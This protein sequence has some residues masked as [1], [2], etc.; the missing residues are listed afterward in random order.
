VLCRDHALDVAR[1]NV[2]GI[3]GKPGRDL[4][5]PFG[6][7]GDPIEPLLPVQRDIIA[8]RLDLEARKRVVDA[9]GLLQTQ[10]VGARL[11]QIIQKM[12]EPLADRVDV[13]G[14]DDQDRTPRRGGENI[15]ARLA[16]AR[17][18]SAC[19]T[20]RR[21]GPT[22]RFLLAGLLA[23]LAHFISGTIGPW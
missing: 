3:A 7:D 17:E 16:G 5:R 9:F 10:R 21:A 4:E 6:E 18:A 1:L 12:G 13:P 2:V 22:A 20:G 15:F 11:L 23:N 8:E 14:G 19:G